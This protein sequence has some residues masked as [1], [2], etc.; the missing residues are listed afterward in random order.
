MLFSLQNHGSMAL[1]VFTEL[2][3]SFF[4]NVENCGFHFFI[5][6]KI[7]GHISSN[8]ESILDPNFESENHTPIQI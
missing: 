5:Y 3:P 7:M 8:R 6:G 1:I 2:L 4:T